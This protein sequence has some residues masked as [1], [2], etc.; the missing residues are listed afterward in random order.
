MRQ[1][2]RKLTLAAV[3][4]LAPLAARA[5]PPR[6]SMAAEIAAGRKIAFTKTLG[7]CIACHVIPGGTQPGNIGPNLTHIRALVPHRKD[8][9]AIIFDEPAR[10]PQAPMPPF[11]RNHILTPAQIR[12]VIA[13]LYSNK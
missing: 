6:P 9:Y 4:L 5:A 7:N 12:Q 13:F 3:G 11:G 8:A 10:K 1:A 2:Y